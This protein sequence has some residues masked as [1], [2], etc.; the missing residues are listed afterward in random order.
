[1]QDIFHE[2]A[3]AVQDGSPKVDYFFKSAVNRKL[4]QELEGKPKVSRSPTPVY[5]QNVDALYNLIEAERNKN[6]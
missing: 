3:I 6:E 2:F 5:D 1:M 4:R